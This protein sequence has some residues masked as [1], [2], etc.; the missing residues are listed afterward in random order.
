MIREGLGSI[1]IATLHSY[2]KKIDDRDY[3][4]T[5]VVNQLTQPIEVILLS[6]GQSSWNPKSIISPQSHSFYDN[7]H[8]LKTVVI[9]ASFAHQKKASEAIFK[10]K[11]CTGNNS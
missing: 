3:I 1:K 6:I 8:N 10:I 4:E 9:P 2:L 11:V 7:P 5:R